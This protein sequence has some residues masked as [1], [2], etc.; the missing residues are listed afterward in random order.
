MFIIMKSRMSW[1]L[2]HVGSKTRSQAQLI[3]KPV[4]HSRDHIFHPIFMKFGL[5]VPHNIALVEYKICV[6]WCPKWG[7]GV[8]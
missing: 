7:H 1:N 3:E 5:Y 4:F 2:G 8:K 6:T